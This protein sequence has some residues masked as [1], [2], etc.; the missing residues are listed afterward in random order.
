MTRRFFDRRLHHARMFFGKLLP[1]VAIIVVLLLLTP[2]SVSAQTEPGAPARAVLT[3]LNG[4]MTYI[5]RQIAELR[6]SGTVIPGNKCEATGWAIGS[7]S[8]F[9]LGWD[10]FNQ[11]VDVVKQNKCLTNDI[12]QIENRI[13]RIAREASRSELTCRIDKVD[14]VTDIIDQAYFLKSAL[15]TYAHL[16]P[17]DEARA[18][19]NDNHP[20]QEFKR[21]YGFV[22]T[23]LSAP[24]FSLV[25]PQY[26]KESLCADPQ[27]FFSFHQVREQIESLLHK[28]DEIG[29]LAGDFGSTATGFAS[30]RSTLFSDSSWE[31]MRNKGKYDARSWYSRNIQQPIDEVFFLGYDK[32][33]TPDVAKSPED[34]RK[35]I[36]QLGDKAMV[37]RA[38]TFCE[39]VYGEGS[40]RC[41]SEE[42]VNAIQSLNSVNAFPMPG[43]APAASGEEDQ[44]AQREIPEIMDRESE[45][46]EDAKEFMEYALLTV[47]APAE[48]SPAI[49]EAIEQP[50]ITLPKKV[51]QTTKFLE[52]VYELILNVCRRHSACA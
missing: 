2:A 41:P 37:G 51:D 48:I 43:D 20:L 3:W 46:V 16:T 39:I 24:D 19:A 47:K 13:Q 27:S 25:E 11:S 49:S 12:N 33:E 40:E 50:L 44:L 42:E 4:R 6:A 29:K 36:L 34:L 31:T 15:E 1:T 10:D 18:R 7:E 8:R 23:E 32:T 22:P 21:R 14:M 45:Y 30:G 52:T 9:R 38:R 28:L 35:S 17:E 5:D 26:Q